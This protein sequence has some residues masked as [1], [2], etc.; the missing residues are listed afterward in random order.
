VRGPVV[1]AA[2][3]CLVAIPAC[4]D[5]SSTD[6]CDGTKVEV[7]GVHP[8][9]SYWSNPLGRGAR[10][11]SVS[12]AA[13]SLRFEPQPPHK[14]GVPERTLVSAS[15]VP[16]AKRKIVWV[17]RGDRFRFF[18]SERL[19]HYSQ[20]RLKHQ[21]AACVVEEDHQRRPGYSMINLDD[22]T[23]ALLIAQSIVMSVT[24]LRADETE[25]GTRTV[26][27]QI[28]MPGRTANSDAAVAIANAIQK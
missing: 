14:L 26:E 5:S 15:S 25:A 8:G 4:A 9:G 10:V 17:Y 19:V 20:A 1:L 11:V 2:L 28:R 6:G 22:G 13:A 3:T 21:A 7:E 24:F 12:R 16:R 23:P 18:V 27:V